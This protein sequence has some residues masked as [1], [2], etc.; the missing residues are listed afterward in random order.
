M[1]P[2]PIYTDELGRLPL[3]GH[4]YYPRYGIE[5][6]Q[7]QG[8]HPLFG[9]DDFSLFQELPMTDFQDVNPIRDGQPQPAIPVEKEWDQNFDPFLSF[10]LDMV[11]Q[12]AVDGNPLSMWSHAPTT[13]GYVDLPSPRQL[14]IHY[15]SD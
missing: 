12:T 11:A 3:R 5:L 9:P 14:L 10:D 2:L 6:S 8:V 13:F 1:S 7:A 15:S 4:S